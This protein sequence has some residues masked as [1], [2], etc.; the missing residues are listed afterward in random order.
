MKITTVEKY[1][2]YI[3]I[4]NKEMYIFINLY[5]YRKMGYIYFS[6]DDNITNSK[7]LSRNGRFAC[8]QPRIS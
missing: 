2:S 1:I 3:F 6:H 4:Y 5:I 7:I 8:V